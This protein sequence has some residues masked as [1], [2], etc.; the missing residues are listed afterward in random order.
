[1]IA[2]LLLIIIYL[3]FISLGLPDSVLGTAIP[4]FQG[5]WGIPL[6]A[7]GIISLLIIAGSTASTFSNAF[8]VKRIGTGKL[9]FFS[10]LLTGS[11]L[12]GFSL[13]PSFF[14]LP[15]L[16]VPLG[17]GGGA[18]D[19]SLNSYVAHNFKARHMNWL[20][21]FWGIGAT[22]GPVIMARALAMTGNWRMGYRSIAFI[23][24]ILA[25]VLL[26]SLPLWKKHAPVGSKDEEN[27][28]GR[29]KTAVFKLKGI[30]PAL[31]TMLLYCSVEGGAGL[32]G[33]SFLAKSR[34][35]PVD[36][37]AGWLAM[38]YG[39]I[40]GGR[41]LAGFITEKLSNN[42][43]IRYGILLSLFGILLLFLPMPPALLGS[44]FILI[45]IGFAPVFPAMIH[46]TPAR[47]GK[48]LSH[49]VIGFQMGFAYIG[50]AA[51][52]PLMGILFQTAGT[53]VFPA[54]LFLLTAAM[55]AVSEILRR[56]TEAGK[57]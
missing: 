42:Q 7:G 43:M 46:E 9:T 21:S 34:G 5:E 27:E 57:K 44:A 17:I 28:S 47:F 49:K 37:A 13:A 1:M 14:W 33:S 39:G 16:A 20:H 52:P 2:V 30:I 31:G 40:T 18:V 54:A 3:S 4:S 6:S 56:E 32:W 8:I 50:S 10:C 22:L 45:G 51:F 29:T 12:L 11:A 53:G 23:Q 38:Y 26:I 15:F 25:N 55:L 19:A 41:F 24:L 36:A 48:Q 35:L